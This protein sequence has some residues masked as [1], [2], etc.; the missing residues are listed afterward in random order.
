MRTFV[1]VAAGRARHA[2]FAARAA[3]ITVRRR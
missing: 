3:R 1:V 2:P